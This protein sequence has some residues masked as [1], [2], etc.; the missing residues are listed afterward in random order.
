V[1]KVKNKNQLLIGKQLAFI[2]CSVVGA[3]EVDVDRVDNGKRAIAS[4][5]AG[6][7]HKY[8]DAVCATDV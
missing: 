8:D 7:I 3:V 4:P 6:R 1:V 5:R 2:G